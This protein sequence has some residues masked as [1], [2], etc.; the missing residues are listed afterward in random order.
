MK[1]TFFIL[2][3]AAL[4][5]SITLRSQ[6]P[7]IQPCDTYAA[8]EQ[9]FT[10]N[11]EARV[12]YEKTQQTLRDELQ[13][14]KASQASAK[15]AAVE[16]TIPVVFHILHQGGVEN[17][18]DATCIAALNQINSDYA[19]MGSDVG[20]IAPPFGN[21][22]IP[23]DIKL[24]LAKK[25][26]NGN[27]TNGI[28]H[29]YDSRT[30][31]DRNV[32]SGSSAWANQYSGITWNPTRYLNIIIVKTIVA[33]QGQVGTV[34]GYTFPPGN[35]PATLCDAVVYTY[36]FLSGLQA[37]SLSHEVGHW[38]NLAHTFGPTNNPGI[39]CGDDGISDTPPT[40]GYFSTCPSSASG[41]VCAV[42]STTAYAAGQAN[43]ENIMDYSSCPKNFTQ[44]QTAVMRTTLISSTAGRNNLSSATNLSSLYTDVNGT[45]A[46]APIADFY[47]SSL[48]FTVCKGGSLTFKDY[49]YNGTIGTLQWAA[50]N[51]AVIASPNAANTSISFPAIGVCNVSLT[52]SNANGSNTVVKQVMVIDNT[53]GMV[54]PVVEGFEGS[55]LPANWQVVNPNPG[56]VTWVQTNQSAYEGSNC[57]YIN[58]LGNVANQEDM[59]VTPVIDLLNAPQSKLSFW[60]AY[61]K[62]T[63]TTN[64]ELNIEGS[65]DCGGS[66]QNFYT[67]T[68]NNMAI[69][70]GGTS[71]TPFFPQP[72]EWKMYDMSLHPNWNGYLS[73]SNVMFRFR[74]K[75]AG[76]GNYIYLD[77]VN[78]DAPLG[79]NELTRS[80]RFTLYPNPS[81]SETSVGFSLNDAAQVSLQVS[82]ISGRVLYSQPATQFTSGEH[83]ITI[84]ADQSLRS[85]I[86]FVEL[87]VNGAR[88]SK[89]LVI[90]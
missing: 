37:R 61:A 24:M 71:N 28:V 30:V 29:H 12:S 44:E 40:K 64:D 49:S 4:L 7:V 65:K 72:N 23:S 33:A 42:S 54:G 9:Y 87:S 20:T 32:L 74:F 90:E 88:M 5:N 1:K 81:K 14:Y 13:A 2:I 10:S 39:N 83:R 51:G 31:W 48:S 8:L 56:T 41:N 22:Y 75:S 73:S 86:Y 17:I 80:T 27:C 35:A 38:L 6:S 34:V 11:P 25:D 63:S 58:N 60:Y 79:I 89:K 52:A 78:L 69:G 66:W 57:F 76:V 45:G 46:C 3:S 15:T 47:T 18:S 59:L 50:D 55:G 26:P 16:Y 21:L 85:G 70:S 43:V 36:S 67:M 82:D 19:K 62:Y 53:P 77:A 68:A 84:N